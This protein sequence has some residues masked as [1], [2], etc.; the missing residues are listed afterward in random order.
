ML[1]RALAQNAKILIMDE[2]TANLDYG[3][4]Q[5]VLRHIKKMAQQGYTI[6]MST[7]NPDP[8]LQYAT[9]VIAIKDHRILAQ[10]SARD[11]MDEALIKELYGLDARILEVQDGGQTIRSC[12]PVNTSESIDQVE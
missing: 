1:A 12:V 2:P 3:N 8:V 11:V 4:Q 9:H 6:L 7:H 10:G 5:R